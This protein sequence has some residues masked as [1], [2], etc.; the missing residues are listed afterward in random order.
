IALMIIALQP[1]I[2]L[3]I[4]APAMP[5]HIALKLSGGQMGKRAA[6]AAI[7]VSV[8]FGAV[9]PGAAAA[10]N[11]CCFCSSG[12]KCDNANANGCAAQM[13]NDPTCVFTLGGSCQSDTC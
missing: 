8:L 6:L 11:G 1:L 13:N 3:E 9:G 7:I 12:P 5:E 2:S 10:Q 4:K